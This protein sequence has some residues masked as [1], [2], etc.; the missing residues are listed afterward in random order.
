MGVPLIHA[1]KRIDGH[2]EENSR[3]SQLLHECAQNC[4]KSR[5]YVG[6]CII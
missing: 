2:D 4:R 3:I 6:L 5:M 1:D